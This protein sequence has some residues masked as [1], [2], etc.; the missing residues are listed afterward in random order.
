M[1]EGK[2]MSN[3]KKPRIAYSGIK[4]AYA[5]IAA[6]KIMGGCERISYPSF[7]SAYEAVANGEC[8]YGVMPIENSFAGD[9]AQV[10][11]L[12]FFGDLS[13]VGIYEMPIVHHLLGLPGADISMIRTVSSHPQALDQCHGF[14]KEHGFTPQ[15]ASNTAVAARDVAEGD[16]MSVAAIASSETA[17]AYGLQILE[18][19]INEKEDNMTRFIV[20]SRND[21]PLEPKRQAFSMILTVK[22][23]A[24]AIAKAVTAIGDAGYNMRVIRSR[25]VRSLAWSYYFYIEGEGDLKTENGDRM[26]SELKKNCEIVRILGNY[27]ADIVLG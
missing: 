18:H 4:G 1:Q 26:M 21:E 13:I 17:E 24:G 7:G 15:S 23:V 20:I 6:E 11:D 14:I 12:L 10:T 3:E 19:G 5:Y 9:V 16:D 22:N 2:N 8:D 27:H 25:P